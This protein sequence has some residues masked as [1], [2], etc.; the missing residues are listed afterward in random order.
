M[1][2]TQQA[3]QALHCLLSMT[4]HAHPDLPCFLRRLLSFSVDFESQGCRGIRAA[5]ES[6]PDSG[7]TDRR[8]GRRRQGQGFE[9]GG[10]GRCAAHQAAAATRQLQSV[11]DKTEEEDHHEM[12]ACILC[13]VHSTEPRC[14][15]AIRLQRDSSLPASSASHSLL[16]P[17]AF[18]MSQ[19][20]LRK[21]PQCGL[22]FGENDVKNL[23]L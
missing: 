10:V 15:S 18:L 17:A 23:Y 3:Q 12:Y 13:G 11:R 7:A 9:L 5:E 2:T 22:K 20:R 16:L 1:T 8:V 14:Q 19:T 21:C 4:P 6:L